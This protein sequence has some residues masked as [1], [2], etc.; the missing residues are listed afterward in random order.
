MYD[1]R[2]DAASLED[3]TRIYRSDV[4]GNTYGEDGYEIN[5]KNIHIPGNAPGWER[6]KHA[7]NSVAR[8]EKSLSG[9]KNY[10]N[11][12]LDSANKHMQNSDEPPSLNEL[13]SFKGDIETSIPKSVKQYYT[14]GAPLQKLR[15]SWSCVYSQ[16]LEIL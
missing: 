15:A 11:D 2:S 9:I 6:Y 13:E 16:S 10:R 7:S 8:I 12:V 4:S 1:I 3:G 14:S 5:H